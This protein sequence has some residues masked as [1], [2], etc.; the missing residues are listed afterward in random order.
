MAD[1]A[2]QFTAFMGAAARP[3]GDGEVSQTA[4]SKL[5]QLGLKTLKRF[6]QDV[7][8]GS[9][10]G[11][12]VG[13][14]LLRHAFVECGSAAAAFANDGTDADR[15]FKLMDLRRK[16]DD[17]V[18]SP[19]DAREASRKRQK[20]EDRV[21]KALEIDGKH[22]DKDADSSKPQYAASQMVLLD[23]ENSSGELRQKLSE[24][25]TATPGG[26]AST[27][28]SPGSPPLPTLVVK[29]F[30]SNVQLVAAPGSLTAGL[31]RHQRAF[32]THLGRLL[33][34]NHAESP[35]LGESEP[36]RLVAQQLFSGSW[37]RSRMVGMITALEGDSPNSVPSV[38]EWRHKE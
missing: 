28:L 35:A 25:A 2:A 17:G 19:D 38:G 13:E 22:K 32:V 7:W 14:G 8:D 21:Q 15:A 1:G 6:D 16:R 27:Y 29:L 24:V 37:R 33:N 36:F 5:L 26:F 12:S 4:W 10:D 31:Q 20:A 30:R 3:T 9:T 34:P 23:I 11:I 18:V